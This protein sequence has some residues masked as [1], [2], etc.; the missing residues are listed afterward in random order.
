MVD[1]FIIMLTPTAANQ[2]GEKMKELSNNVIDEEEKRLTAWVDDANGILAF[3]SL[4][5]LAPLFIILMRGLKTGLF[6]ATVGAFIIE[7][8]KK[9][10]ADPGDQTADLLGQISQQLANTRNGAAA[11]QSFSPTVWMISVNGMW[12]MSLVFSITSALITLLNQQAVRRYVETSKAPNGRNDHATRVRSSA[13][14]Q[15]LKSYKMPLAIF[16]APALLHLSIS[17][18][19]AGLVIAF[20]TI[21][22]KVA[23]AVDVAVVISGLVYLA[24]SLIPLLDP[25]NC[26]YRTPLTYILLYS[27]IAFVY[28]AAYCGLLLIGIRLPG[29]PCLCPCSCG[30]GP[31]PLDSDSLDGAGSKKRR[32]I[33]TNL[34]NSLEKTVEEYGRY[35]TDGVPESV[36]DHTTNP[37]E[38]PEEDRKTITWLFRQLSLGDK[39]KF[40]VFAA[41]IPRHK[42]I[43]LI[44]PIK[45]GEIQVDLWQPLLVLLRS[46]TDTGPVGP[47]EDVR[48]DALLVC[49]TA[50][51]DIAKQSPIPDLNFVRDKFASILMRRGGLW[52]NIDNS[53]RITSRSIC[54][55][56]ARQVVR[57]RRRG[58]IEDADIS[59]LQ[60][61][62]GSPSDVIREA[63]GTVLDQIIFKSFVFG[64]LPNNAIHLSVEDA[65]SF[66][67]TLAILLDIRTNIRNFTTRDWQIR[68]SEEAGRIQQYDPNGAR[69]VLHRLHSVFPAPPV[70][71]ARSI[72]SST[73]T[74]GPYP[75]VVPTPR[76]ASSYS[77]PVPRSAP[78]HTT[79]PS[80]S[81][82]PSFPIPVPRQT[83]SH[84]TVSSPS[85]P[86]SFPVPVRRRTPSLTTVSS[87]SVPPSFSVPVRRRTPSL[88]TMSSPS[89][90]QAPTPRVAPSPVVHPPS[91]PSTPRTASLSR[92]TRRSY[93]A[94]P[95][96]EPI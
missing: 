2:L 8:Y 13:G 63:G 76:S 41:S 93:T 15:K 73:H 36:I 60:E 94:H 44:P 46:C 50:I 11:T 43:D 39:N 62:S 91:V 95:P 18:F 16:A 47:G 92:T 40:L 75:P 90:P 31:D 79:V 74:E 49:L 28:F 34:S 37:L 64:A 32:H 19:F 77:F 29:C 25:K 71:I 9:L 68:L 83:P 58:G 82:P 81:V 17:L 56:V 48:R 96:Y 12:L 89:V 4:D 87:P 59:W 53:I 80:P 30:C 61:V 14:L 66:K 38:E 24:M 52:N 42:V 67:E 10:S 55:L 22:L 69:E 57:K 33:L 7:F 54:A 35:L 85:V 20:H 88:T 6:S 65:T 21:Y 45:S 70:N 3:V 84:T 1:N 51:H 5:L 78:S 26:P 86:P 72:P 23:I 27:R